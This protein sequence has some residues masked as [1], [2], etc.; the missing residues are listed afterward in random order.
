MGTSQLSVASKGLIQR[1]SSQAASNSLQLSHAIARPFRRLAS[2]R[3]TD[4]G[5]VGDGWTLT[6][7]ASLEIKS[8]QRA[9]E[10]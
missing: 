2:H 6:L 9:L 8:E 5:S 1:P 4:L 10:E 7:H 3:T